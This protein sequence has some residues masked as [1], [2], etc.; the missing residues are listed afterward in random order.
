MTQQFRSRV[1]TPKNQKTGTQTDAHADL[2][3]AAPFTTAQRV[4]T[5]QMATDG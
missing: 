5:T 1:Y 3:T 4:D 2:F